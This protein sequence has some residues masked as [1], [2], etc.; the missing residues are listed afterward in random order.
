M[1]DATIVKTVFFEAS[2]ES[3]WEFLTKKEKLALWFFD[4][5][6]DLVDGQAL[7]R[8]EKRRWDY[9]RRWMRAGTRILPRCALR[10]IRLF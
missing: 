5:E 8:P 3:V 2:R 1:S 7:A 6:A 9:S 4:A 10:W